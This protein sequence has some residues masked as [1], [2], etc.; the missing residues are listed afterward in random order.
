MDAAV[1][2][3]ILASV[4]AGALV[5]VLGAGGMAVAVGGPSYPA[6]VVEGACGAGPVEASPDWAPAQKASAWFGAHG[7][8]AE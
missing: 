1:R 6:D 2:R 5:G 8:A 4:S 3:R 7:R